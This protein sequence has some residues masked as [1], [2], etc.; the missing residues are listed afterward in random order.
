M[1][2]T[3]AAVSNHCQPRNSS[4]TRRHTCLMIV[5]TAF[6]GV[7]I[8]AMTGSALIIWAS[9]IVQLAACVMYVI[10]LVKA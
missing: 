6:T 7:C 3:V 5:L 4:D 8:G 9:G 1:P 2:T 10:A